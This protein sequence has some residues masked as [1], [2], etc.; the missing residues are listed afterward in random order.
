MRERAARIKAI[1]WNKYRVKIMEGLCD[2]G[3]PQAW[4]GHYASTCLRTACALF[5]CERK[6]EGYEWLE[7]AFNAFPKWDS[8]PDGT[9]ME[10][11]DPLIFGGV[12]VVKGKSFMII[13]DGR[14]EPIINSFMFDDIRWLLYY[15][16]TAP[17][18][19]EWFNPVRN[20][21]R[22]KEYIERARIMNEKNS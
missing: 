5:G 20:E 3:V 6:E 22:F 11:G 13:P 15:S 1:A 18:G 4:L 14:K 2:G 19:W 17:H 8:I 9:E 7:K 10:V 12:K 16:L 21:E